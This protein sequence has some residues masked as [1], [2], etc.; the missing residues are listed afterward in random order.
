AARARRGAR[1]AEGVQPARRAG[2][3]IPL[4]RR[5]RL[6]RDRGAHEHLVDHR[7]PG[8]GRGPRVAAPRARRRAPRPRGRPVRPR[9]SVV[10]KPTDPTAGRWGRIE[11]LFA[12]A[13]EL[14]A[15]ERAA[16][17]E[18]VGPAP[19][20]R[21]EVEALLAVRDAP[22]DGLLDETPPWVRAWDGEDDGG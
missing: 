22:T 16:F 14:P 1:P 17:R 12:G 6:R 13:V 20:L 5:T 4:L 19:A 18:R 21:A 3:R 2:R 7:A 11:A 15:T 9:R 10:M 8:L